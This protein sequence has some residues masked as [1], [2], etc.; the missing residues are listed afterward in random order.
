MTNN[1]REPS[2]ADDRRTPLT[3]AISAADDGTLE[4]NVRGPAEA[5]ENGG[6]QEE[7]LATILSEMTDQIAQ[8]QFV[9]LETRCR[10]HP[11]LADDLRQLWGAVLITDVTGNARTE[12][13]THRSGRWRKMTLPTQVGDYELLE[14]IG[15]GGMGVVF[16]ARQL[17]LQREVAI[18]MILR[19][20]LASE[21]DFQRFLA[22]ATTAA[23]L[24]HPHIV[25]VY[26][27]G[28]VE[29]RPYFSMKFVAG[30]TLADRLSNGPLPQR[31]A[32]KIV[33]KVSR[34]IAAAHRAGILHRDIKPSNILL[35]V[36][37]EPLVTDFGL[38]KVD[39]L[40][41]SLTSS[42]MVL[43]T[44]AYMSPEQASGRRSQVTAA[45]DVY[46]LGCVLYHALTGRA[47]LVADSPVELMLK[48]L[49]Q[50]PPPPRLLRGNLDRD[51]EMIV[52]RCLQKPVDLRYASADSFA[53]DL[54][55]F[56]NDERISARSGRFNQVVA[57]LFRETHH[58][59]VLQNWGLLW[60]W[61]SL[62]LLLACLATWG[63]QQ[64]GFTNRLAYAGLW[65]VGLGAWAGVFWWLRRR[66]GPVTFIERQTAHVWASSMFA[67]AMLFPLE[68]WM[69]LPVLTL[70]P[71]LAVI[72][73]MVFLVK[74]SMYSGEFYIQFAV[75]L[76]TS[77]V[78]AASPGYAHVVFGIAAAACFFVPGLKYYRQKQ[79]GETA[80]LTTLS[81]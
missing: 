70:S 60:I 63:L 77:F 3:A 80:R 36:D 20:R 24:E 31:M 58:A 74:A 9:D 75:M 49:E 32:A 56:L 19:G 43:G 67:V 28:D 18:K 53:D 29:G 13:T 23:R 1:R 33:S 47:P 45:S 15:R 8:G 25:P 69:D 7:R 68:W 35:T 12:L 17:S 5:Q 38:A 51:L 10:Q 14:E 11:D 62:A 78:M 22:E 71:V 54:D 66:L 73:S 34:A 21:A 52:I 64:A 72:A 40:A 42:G 59:S 37:D 4:G 76:I 50:D 46:S 26:E 57:R 39:N 30:E 44:P 65:T 16:R 55:A 27:I 61:H 48:V 41:H 81:E 79:L 2:P 6:A